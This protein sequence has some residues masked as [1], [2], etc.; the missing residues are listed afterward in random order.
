MVSPVMHPQFE[1]WHFAGMRAM[2]LRAFLLI[3][4]L[5]ASLPRPVSAQGTLIRFETLSVENGLS[6][7]TVRAIIQDSQGFMWFGTEDGLNKY[8]GY[9]FTLYKHD[10][11][12]P[13]SVIDNTI[14]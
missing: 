11:A 14:T 7:S 13:H 9:N 10:T 2:V 8:D 4:I 6:Q 1:Q 3:V 12:N 5:L